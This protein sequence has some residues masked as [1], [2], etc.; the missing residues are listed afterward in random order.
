MYREII[1][2]K[3][4]SLYMENIEL[5]Y[6]GSCYLFD[7]F[8]SSFLG[9]GEGKSKFGHGIYITTSFETAARY[10]SKAAKANGKECCYVYTV[11]VPTL[12]DGLLGTACK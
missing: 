3:E 7:K 8:S 2:I 12:V 5:L 9:C 4:E 1:R 10:A 11:E 6:H